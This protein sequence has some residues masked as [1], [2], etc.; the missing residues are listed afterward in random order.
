MSLVSNEACAEAALAMRAV[1]VAAA[2][3]TTLD[4]ISRNIL[5]SFSGPGRNCPAMLRH[6]PEISLGAIIVRT[7]QPLGDVQA[8][9]RNEERHANLI[10]LLKRRHSVLPR[11]RVH[12]N[13]G[14]T[15]AGCR[16]ERTILAG[17]ILHQLLL[18]LGWVRP[19]AP[20]PS[21]RPCGRAAA[22]R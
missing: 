3:A 13:L 18:G 11:R 6:G 2:T 10:R 4:F 22:S 14:R 7:E 19:S 12:P 20:K 15:L 16:I 5:F 8:D 17:Q 9:Q 21:A 1:E